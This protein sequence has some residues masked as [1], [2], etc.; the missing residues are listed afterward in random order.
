MNEAFLFLTNWCLE[1]PGSEFGIRMIPISSGLLGYEFMAGIKL[2]LKPG[3]EAKDQKIV[4]MKQAVGS[5]ALLSEQDKNS[6]IIYIW[7][8][9]TRALI[10]EAEKQLRII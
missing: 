3:Q 4:S 10:I 6:A 2:P 5:T 7:S 1:H 9:V 8:Q